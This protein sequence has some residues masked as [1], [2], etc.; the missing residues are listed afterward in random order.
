MFAPK[1]IRIATQYIHEHFHNEPF[2]A[3]HVRA[4]DFKTHHPDSILDVDGYVAFL[5]HE[6][7]VLQHHTTHIFIASNMDET[8]RQELHRKLNFS[9]FLLDTSS[10]FATLHPGQVAIVDQ[11]ICSEAVQFIGTKESFFTGIIEEEIARKQGLE[12]LIDKRYFT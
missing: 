3:A 2:I 1:L 11:T 5:E 6:A 4:G 7:S 12:K 8:M 10:V 9:S